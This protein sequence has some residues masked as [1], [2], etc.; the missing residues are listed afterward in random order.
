MS[1]SS[2]A[3]Q[4]WHSL[5]FIPSRTSAAITP[6]LWIAVTGIL[7]F[8]PDLGLGISPSR[9]LV[10]VCFLCLLVSGLNLSYGFAGELSFASPAFY[11]LGSY[12][13]VIVTAHW[14]NDI[15][16]CLVVGIIGGL[17]DK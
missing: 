8:A 15:A 4:A 12:V 16:V 5:L 17:L 2:R 1:M 6:V 3:G 7:A 11:A 14:V 13:T 10:L 9:Q